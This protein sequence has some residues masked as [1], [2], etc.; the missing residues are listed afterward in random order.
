MTYIDPLEVVRNPETL[1]AYRRYRREMYASAR[2]W[3]VIAAIAAPTEIGVT[4][5][6]LFGHGGRNLSLVSSAVLLVFGLSFA[7]ASWRMWRFTRS[8][9]FQLP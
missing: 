8:H 7:I 1:A 9:P 3:L 6:G 5:Y 2:V 4:L